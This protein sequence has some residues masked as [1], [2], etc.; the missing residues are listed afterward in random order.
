MYAQ[1]I[2][3]PGAK[4]D[5]SNML[6]A[7]LCFLGMGAWIYHEIAQEMFT[8]ILTLGVLAQALAFLLLYMQI[9]ANQ[10]V[11]GISGKCLILHA[12]KLCCRL[13]TTLWLQGYL[14][15][16]ASGDWIY[17]LGDILSLLLVLKIMFFIFFE[18]KASYEHNHD[19]LGI[20][21]MIVGAVALAIV[22]HPDLIDWVPFDI[23][24]TVHLYVDTV[25]MVPQLWMISKAGGKVKGV[26][27]HYI[28]AIFL[29]NILTG[30]FWF[31]AI[32]ELRG[33]NMVNVAGLAINGAHLVQL[34]LL[35]DFA[36]F[37]VKACLQ[38]Q[39]RDPT[40]LMARQGLDI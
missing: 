31:H 12:V 24:W 11:A 33:L 8:S 5:S 35:L 36:Y 19:T 9:S 26:T 2:M 18:Y 30:V 37:Y 29:S 21:N 40:M 39:G 23:L 14:P 32:P 7:W 17:Q 20:K 25:A 3:K 1:H 16:D 13:G 27:A 10:S 6:I 38:G 22:F 28:A 15:A 4:G 34:L